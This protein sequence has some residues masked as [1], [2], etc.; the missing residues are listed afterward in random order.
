MTRRS[1]AEL[2]VAIV[3]E[4][5]END[6]RRVPELRRLGWRGPGWYYW[7]AAFDHCHG[8]FAD[9]TTC[10]H[11]YKTATEPDTEV[12]VVCEQG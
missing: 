3:E 12:R 7:N 11:A 6:A 2:A 9:A 4:L 5:G 10:E 1:T 8:P